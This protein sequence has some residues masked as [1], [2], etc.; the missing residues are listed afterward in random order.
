MGV[1][2]AFLQIKNILFFKLHQIGLPK[3]LLC[4][5]TEKSA[6]NLGNLLWMSYNV[7]NPKKCVFK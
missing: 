4:Y 3:F 2:L 1:I 7:N 6:V 5:V